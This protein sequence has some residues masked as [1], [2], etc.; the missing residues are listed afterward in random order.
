[1]KWLKMATNPQSPFDPFHIDPPPEEGSWFIDHGAFRPRSRN[2]LRRLIGAAVA[3]VS[4]G[5]A[6]GLGYFWFAIP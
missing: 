1:M 6:A 5:A 4:A 2:S 3:V